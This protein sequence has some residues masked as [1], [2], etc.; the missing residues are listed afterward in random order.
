MKTR[1]PRPVVIGPKLRAL[2]LKRGRFGVKTC[3]GDPIPGHPEH[4]LDRNRC[5][6]YWQGRQ[7]RVEWKLEAMAKARG[8]GVSYPGLYPV[9]TTK[10]GRDVHL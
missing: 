8:L 5:A 1:L 6:T 9:F 4:D 3:N 2:A 10:D 7:D